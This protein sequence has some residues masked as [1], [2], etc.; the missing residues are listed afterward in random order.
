MASLSLAICMRRS[1]GN[2]VCDSLYMNCGPSQYIHSVDTTDIDQSACS[3]ESTYVATLASKLSEVFS[4][5]LEE[6]HVSQSN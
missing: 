1:L 5:K 6:F 3:A 4:S 2:I